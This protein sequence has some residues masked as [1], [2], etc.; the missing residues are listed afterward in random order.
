MISKPKPD[1]RNKEK[2]LKCEAE[3]FISFKNIIQ[4]LSLGS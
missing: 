1:Q 2:R 4:A 3:I